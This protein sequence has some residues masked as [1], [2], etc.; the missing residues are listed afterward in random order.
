MSSVDSSSSVHVFIQNYCKVGRTLTHSH[1][2]FLYI[3]SMINMNVKTTDS[4]TAM[5]IEVVMLM[6]WISSS[7]VGQSVPA[8]IMI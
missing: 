5:T 6:F 8:G 2:D 4:T 1:F 7:R 3:T